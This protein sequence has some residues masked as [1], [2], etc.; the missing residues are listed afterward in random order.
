[1]TGMDVEELI[2]RHPLGGDVWHDRGMSHEVFRHVRFPFVDA[3]FPASL[4][5]VVQ[6]TVLEGTEPARAVIHSDDGSWLV[7]DGVND[8][9]LPGAVVVVGIT[10]VV[11]RDRS[12]AELATLPPGC[13]A[14]RDS[15][16]DAWHVRS[17]EWARDEGV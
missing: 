8:P 11:E 1:M 10:H 4:G 16:D 2:A 7:G 5:A 14:E 3:R 9:N 13:I 15:P 12:L 17:Q 6:R